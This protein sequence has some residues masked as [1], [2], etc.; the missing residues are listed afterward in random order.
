MRHL[1][2]RVAVV[3][4]AA[5]GI[6][7]A[8]AVALAAEGCRLALVDVDDGAL[9]ATAKVARAS[10]ATVSTHV[11]DV[12]NKARM[13]ALPAEIGGEHGGVD[14]L[15]NNAGVTV[16]GTF[17]EQTIE[18][19]EHVIGVNLW[20]VIYGCKFFLPWLE[21]S[22]DARIVNI[23]SVFGILGVPGQ[24]SYCA[25][26]FGVRGLSEAL[27]EEF[28]GS[29]I[30][31]TVVHPG[32]VATNIVTSSKTYDEANAGRTADLF[33]KTGIT[34]ERAADVIVRGIKR[35]SKRVLI[36]REAY[37]FDWLKRWM[38][39]TGNRLVAE[40]IIKA[41]GLNAER[42]E[43][44]AERRAALAARRGTGVPPALVAVSDEQGA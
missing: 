7:R 9:E 5:S 39:R 10:G 43:R 29:H 41:F 18:D 4:G 31:V 27:W 20:G 36:T 33:A 30:G 38:P 14:L 8:L 1:K 6:G 23:S 26:K 32:G 17:G 28:G 13:Q 22:P 12:S 16:A 40:L 3:T 35:G 34:P 11:A 24:T 25:S 44:R 15:V 19:W 21:R 2:D 37:V 42:A